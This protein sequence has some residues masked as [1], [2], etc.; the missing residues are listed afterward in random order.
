MGVGTYEAYIERMKKMKPTFI[1]TANAWTGWDRGMRG[2][3]WVMKQCYDIA[4]DPN[5]QMSV[6]P[7]PIS[8]GRPST[9]VPISTIHRMIC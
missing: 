4:N 2:G 9:A 7:P 8:Q 5:M 3:F 6:Q 1:W